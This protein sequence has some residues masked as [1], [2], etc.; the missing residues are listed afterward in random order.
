MP[1]SRIATISSEVATGRRMNRREGFIRQVR[2]LFGRLLA[3]FSATAFVATAFIA[4]AAIAAALSGVVLPAAAFSSIVLSAAALSGVALPAA[5]FCAITFVAALV[6]AAFIVSV[7]VAALPAPA[8]FPACAIA[9]FARRGR[10][11]G[12]QFD[13]R[14][15]AQTVHAVDDHQFARFDARFDYSGVVLGG[16]RFHLAQGDCL[17]LFNHGDEKTSRAA[18]QCG[19]GHC[20]HVAP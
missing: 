4:T 10:I 14:A 20:R 13:P 5:A 9:T 7:S 17:V 6:A 8:A 3:A 12:R 1:D 16:T 2:Q 11:P 19:A 18:L 15:F